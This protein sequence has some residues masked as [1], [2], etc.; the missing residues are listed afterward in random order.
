MCRVNV[1]LDRALFVSQ[2]GWMARKM[3]EAGEASL[4]EIVRW[5][6]TELS[7]DRGEEAPEDTRK[8]RR[9]LLRL[10]RLDSREQKAAEKHLREILGQSFHAR[11]P[12]WRTTDTP[13][14]EVDWTETYRRSLTDRPTRFVNREIEKKPDRELMGAL[15]QQAQQ[16][17]E[18]LR[19]SEK[20][21]HEDRAEE[22]EQAR[23]QAIE[24]NPEVRVRRTGPMTPPLLRR[25]RQKGPQA[26][27][28]SDAL[29]R[30]FA[31][32][33]TT[34]NEIVRTLDRALERA[35]GWWNEED[36]GKDSVWNRLLEL[37]VL[38]AITQTAE[39]SGAWMLRNLPD[40]QGTFMATLEHST[41]PVKL[42]VGKDAPGSDVFKKMRKPMGLADQVEPQD[43]QPD[44]CLTFRHSKTKASISVLGDAKRNATGSGT[45]YFR[46]GLRTATYYLSAFPHV[47]G[48]EVVDAESWSDDNTEAFSGSIRPTVT[49]FFRQGVATDKVDPDEH[50]EIP[51][52]LACDIENHFGLD[53]T[54]SNGK[55]APNEN[56]SSP[57]LTQWL[58]CIS[59]QAIEHLAKQ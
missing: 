28:T 9:L 16:W 33:H 1:D 17:A 19:T 57:F 26:K 6:C 8:L 40:L 51:P 3:G 32:Q 37:S 29:T 58:E 47:L 38:L 25:L 23:K 5:I 15:R 4:A 56:W 2:V 13:G 59:G 46:D 50:S 12:R 39:Q 14:R 21:E 43:S 52:I 53:N 54:S 42:T 36:A 10:L 55:H 30:V 35:E 45:D 20:R 18:L 48:A 24:R 22:L 41:E 34:P 11:S 44:I 49:L 31:H 27:K 7:K